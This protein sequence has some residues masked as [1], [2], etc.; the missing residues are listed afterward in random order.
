MECEYVQ[1]KSKCHPQD[2]PCRSNNWPA[3]YALF[4]IDRHAYRDANCEAKY[5]GAFWT[6]PPRVMRPGKPGV[7]PTPSMICWKVDS[8]CTKPHDIMSYMFWVAVG[9][10]GAFGAQV[11][12]K[13]K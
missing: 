10:A 13:P 7:V 3:L 2:M 11:P 1:L 4:P 9:F 6:A 8:L 5:C 12:G